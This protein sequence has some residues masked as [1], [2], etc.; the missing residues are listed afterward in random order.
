MSLVAAWPTVLTWKSATPC[1]EK[2]TDSRLLPPD[3]VRMASPAEPVKLLTKCRPAP[4]VIP[5]RSI[6]SRPLTKSRI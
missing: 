2:S 1:P 5:V 4:L 6:L 3:E